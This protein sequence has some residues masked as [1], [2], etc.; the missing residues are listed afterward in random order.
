MFWV[1][2]VPVLWKQNEEEAI[3]LRFVLALWVY[4]S[5]FLTLSF[6]VTLYGWPAKQTIPLSVL[7][8]NQTKDFWTWN[9]AV[10]G[11]GKGTRKE[12]WL[13]KG[14]ERQLATGQ[15]RGESAEEL[16]WNHGQ[17]QSTPDTGAVRPAEKIGSSEED[18]VKRCRHSSCFVEFSLVTH[19]SVSLHMHE[20]LH[21]LLLLWVNPKHCSCLFVCPSIFSRSLDRILVVVRNVR[22]P[23][24]GPLVDHR[25]RRKWLEES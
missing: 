21:T 20:V 14:A 13:D 3:H 2:P 8:R 5:R 1:G 23:P 15:Q 24:S 7:A 16:A 25:P 9:L 12:S 22:Y 18:R 10:S 6:T 19:A 17:G 11:S 4:L